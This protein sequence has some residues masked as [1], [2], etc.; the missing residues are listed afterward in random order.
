[1]MIAVKAIYEQ[2]KIEFLE[3]PPEVERALVAVV[4]LAIDPLPDVL[5]A[6]EDIIS[7]AEWGEPIDD[8]GAAALVALHEAL[9]PY[10]L[11]AEQVLLGQGKSSL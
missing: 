1:M 4:F 7:V 6:Y 9:A 8:E 3:P 5:E 10:R 2:G 11:E